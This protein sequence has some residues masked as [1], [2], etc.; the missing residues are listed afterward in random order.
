M[1][2]FSKG[3]DLQAF[4]LGFSNDL[5]QSSAFENARLSDD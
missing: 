2:T 5:Y 1:Q 3:E 4:N